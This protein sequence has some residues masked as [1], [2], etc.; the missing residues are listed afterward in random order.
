MN[1]N[2]LV[3][4]AISLLKPLLPFLP[5]DQINSYV[6]GRVTIPRKIHDGF[7]SGMSDEQRQLSTSCARSSRMRKPITSCLL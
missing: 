7:K 6:Q 1:L 5:T 3:A 2:N 4:A